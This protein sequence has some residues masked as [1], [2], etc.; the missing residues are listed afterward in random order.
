[1]RGELFVVGLGASLVVVT[2]VTVLVARNRSI[3]GAR[4]LLLASVLE[5]LWVCLYFGQIFSPTAAQ[6]LLLA[7]LGW[8]PAVFIP[9]LWVLFVV[10]YTGRGAYLTRARVVG[11][12]T[13]PVVALLAVAVAYESLVRPDVMVTEVDGL[14]AITAGFGPM[15]WFFV[16]YAWL[17]VMSSL[18][19]L[20][21]FIVEQRSLYRKR[22]GALLGA[23]F[24]PQIAS[25][26][27]STGLDG[28]GGLDPTPLSFAVSSGLAAL[29]IVEYDAFDEPPIPRHIATGRAIEAIDDPTFVVDGSDTVVDCN[30]AACAV[31]GLDEQ[32]LVGTPKAT[33]PPLAGVDT[34]E[35]STVTVERDGTMTYYDVQTATVDQ[36]GSHGHG[37]VLTLRDVTDRR[38]RKQRLNAL[39]DVLRATIQ[40]EMATVKQTVDEEGT[41]SDIRAL[42]ERASLALDMT[43]RAGE[44]ASMVEP[45]AESPADIV[46]IIH[47]E[48][49]AAR[50]LHPEVSFV[51]DATLGEWAY[52]SGLFEPVFR[53]SLRHAARR[54]LQSEAEPVVGIS[55]AAGPESVT[56]SVSDRGPAL[57][58]HERT[59]LCEGAEPTPSD[60]A[61]MSRWLVNWGVEQAGGRILVGTDGDHTSLELTFPRTDRE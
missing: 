42:R 23:G 8:V 44:L 41:G 32:S 58:D 7:R 6:T 11:L 28:V 16:G 31:V 40:E 37:R 29:A 50:E 49:E 52:C 51:L 1:M 27:N 22:A 34:A 25:F 10:E 60:R 46:P 4:P 13:P 48:I 12:V 47:E 20:V 39:N 54:S 9:S 3:P 17:L 19:L 43:D 21:E 59:V 33:L 35:D 56:V 57:T 53:V 18:V 61:D 26:L 15:Y 30:P 55:I 36:D 38:E 24:I 2:M 5:L 14:H 45:E